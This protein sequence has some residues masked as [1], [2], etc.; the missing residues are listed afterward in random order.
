MSVMRMTNPQSSLDVTIVI[1]ED[2]ISEST[3][4]SVA[5]LLEAWQPKVVVEAGSYKG[6]F[7]IVAA[8]ASPEAQVYTA[9]A[10]DHNWLFMC[11]HNGVAD[12]VHFV[13]AD[14]EQIAVRH[15][16]IVG[17][18]DLAFVDSGWPMVAHEGGVRYRHFQ[19]AQRWVR[20]GG[21]ILIDDM[22]RRD[23]PGAED[24]AQQCCLVLPTDR[25][26]GIWRRHV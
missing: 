14:F 6:T 3:A 21:Y 26:L 17:Q 12:R 9:D 8:K 2:S 23:W 13:N 16:E 1:N 5:V 18:V 24:I 15:P 10:I 11:E 20:L 25:G 7:A 4:R 22:A 19:A